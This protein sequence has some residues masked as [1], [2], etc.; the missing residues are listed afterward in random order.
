MI[1]SINTKVYK[2]ICLLILTMDKD[3]MC[4]I[5]AILLGMAIVLAVFW[6]ATIVPSFEK[7][8]DG[9]LNKLEQPV[10]DNIEQS[11]FYQSK[12]GEE[13]RKVGAGGA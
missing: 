9:E 6:F 1:M 4:K 3:T 13:Y 7:H 11:E 5:I 12:L 2:R 8:D 10:S